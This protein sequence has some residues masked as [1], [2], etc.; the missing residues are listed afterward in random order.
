MAWSAAGAVVL[1][2]AGPDRTDQLDVECGWANLLM[3]ANCPELFADWLPGW[4]SG[5]RYVA[6]STRRS[7]ATA[8]RPDA[9]LAGSGDWAAV[10]AISSVLRAGCHRLAVYGTCDNSRAGRPG[11]SHGDQAHA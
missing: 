9:F 2:P 11:V 8:P 7:T 10:P 3:G 1:F 6:F 5:N 4:S